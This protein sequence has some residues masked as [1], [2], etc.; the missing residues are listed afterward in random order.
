MRFTIESMRN[1]QFVSFL[2][3][4]AAVVLFF[5]S[6]TLLPPVELYCRFQRPAV[7]LC[8]VQLALLTIRR[9]AP[10]SANDKVLVTATYVFIPLGILFNAV[11]LFIAHGKCG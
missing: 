7:A 8:L 4:G 10:S 3:L 9:W 2:L 1:S 6:L 5:F 11:L